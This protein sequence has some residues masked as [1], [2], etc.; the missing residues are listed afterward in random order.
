MTSTIGSI[1]MRE[2]FEA[3]VECVSV[4]S[5]AGIEVVDLSYLSYCFDEKYVQGGFGA[6][7]LKVIGFFSSKQSMQRR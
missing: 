3:C 6:W 1:W 2:D 7:H 5:I 4:K